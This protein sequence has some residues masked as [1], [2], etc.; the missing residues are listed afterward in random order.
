MRHW[1]F[2]RWAD[3]RSALLLLGQGAR[4]PRCADRRGPVQPLHFLP[5]RL[6]RR[7]T[8]PA[9]PCA[10]PAGRS[11]RSTY[12][13][14]KATCAECKACST[15]R[16]ARHRVRLLD[17]RSAAMSFP[18]A[19]TVKATKQPPRHRLYAKMVLLQ[20][21][22]KQ[23]QRITPDDLA[24]FDEAERQLREQEECLPG[25]PDRAGVQHESSVGLQLYPLASDVQRPPVAL[26]EHSRG[27]N[28]PDRGAS[29]SGTLRLPSVWLS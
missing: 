27:T 1:P 2:P 29:D 15:H 28:P 6:P 9:R 16:Q 7:N 13:A 3:C 18:I 12:D 14:E 5:A 17:A 19:K 23:Y 21:G 8:R 4:M 22:E 25:R 20:D 11:T 24:L 26:P 10:R